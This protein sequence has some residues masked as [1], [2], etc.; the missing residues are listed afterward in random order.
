MK[1]RK[2]AQNSLNLGLNLIRNFTFSSALKLLL[3][4][5][6]LGAQAL[7]PKIVMKPEPS[8]KNGLYFVADK[9]Y[10]GTLKVLHYSAEDLY[11]VNF[12]GVVYPRLKPLPPTLIR[13]IDV[14]DG[15]AVLQRDYFDGRDKP[16]N[17]YPI[18]NGLYDGVAKSYYADGGELRSQSEY[19]AGK[20][21]GFYKLYYQ[22]S[23]KLKQQGAYKADR[24]EGVFTDY[25]ESGEVSARHPYKGGLR[26]GK[27]VDY[28]KSGKVR[29]ERSYKGG[30]RQGVEKWYHANGALR[31]TGAYKDDRKQGVWKLFYENGKTRVVENFKD[32]ERDGA[33]REYY[34][35]GVLQGEYE[36]ERGRLV[37]AK[38]Y[39]ESGKLI[40]DKSDKNGLA[41]E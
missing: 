2:A 36:F 22:G 30:K 25:Y 28:Y 32:G 1:T 23:G 20:R 37:R 40:S 35:S 5:L 12:M 31:Q 17:E 10:N 41:R 9:P 8:L 7:E 26:N 29:G 24:R 16:S 15:T 38:K 11:D 14:K 33:V 27:D 39:D 34:A 18:K 21:E 13:E 6:A 4:F 19:K 3:P